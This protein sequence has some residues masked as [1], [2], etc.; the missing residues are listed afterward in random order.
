[1]YNDLLTSN[2]TLSSKLKKIFVWMALGLLISASVA[3]LVLQSG[4][5]YTIALS[6][7]GYGSL[8]LL[9]AQLGVVILLSKGFRDYTAT[10]CRN[11]FV[12]YSVLTGFTLSVLPIIYDISTIFMA[13]GL[14]SLL[15]V[16]MAI[17]GY[18][19]KKDLTKF[20]PLLMAGLITLIATSILN[21]LFNLSAIEMV[22]NYGAVLLFLALT[23]YDMQKIKKLYYQFE[24]TN[25]YQ[26]MD[27]LTIIGALELYLDF[28]NLF[29]YILR[30]L[31]RKK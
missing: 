1:M 26:M 17:I 29:L 24:T 27:K 3:Y 8:L 11:L 5:W 23:A 22:V 15:F 25:D 19:T 4:L 13:F 21:M 10:T 6:F 2:V 9:F 31:G 16:N 20:G 14:S 28:I 30:I 18:T 12:L 7:G